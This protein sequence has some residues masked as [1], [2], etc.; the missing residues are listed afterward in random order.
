MRWKS[1]DDVESP[2]VIETEKQSVANPSA[3]NM[4]VKTSI[5]HHEVLK[6][7]CLTAN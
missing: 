5:R 1:S 7:F 2:L 3:T 6:T 4:I